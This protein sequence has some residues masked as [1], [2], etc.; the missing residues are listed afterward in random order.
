MRN[1]LI[2]PIRAYQY[3]ISPLLP[4]S[5]RYTPT[6]SEFAIEAVQKHGI[7]AGSWLAI[8]RV[9]RCH[10][11]HEGGYDPVPDNNKQSVQ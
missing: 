5:C 10:P 6:C 7:L 3:L 4:N 1:I 9:G 8:K 11:W 2:L